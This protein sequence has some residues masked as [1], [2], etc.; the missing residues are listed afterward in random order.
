LLGDPLSYPQQRFGQLAQRAPRELIQRQVR[1]RSGPTPD[2]SSLLVE[3]TQD[4]LERGEEAEPFVG[5][6]KVLVEIPM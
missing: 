3:P 1:E 2:R 6:R 5:F 4:L